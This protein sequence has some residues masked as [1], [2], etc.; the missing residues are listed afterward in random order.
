MN[1][2]TMLALVC[3]HPSHVATSFEPNNLEGWHGLPKF[4]SKFPLHRVFLDHETRLRQI[5][6]QIHHLQA[7]KVDAQFD[8]DNQNTTTWQKWDDHVSLSASEIIAISLTFIW[9]QYFGFDL[10]AGPSD[11]NQHHVLM[12]FYG[13]SLIVI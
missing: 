4:S 9:S 8:P 2:M 6:W 7:A 12:R 13:T 3:F 5:Q 11:R 1:H 10:Q